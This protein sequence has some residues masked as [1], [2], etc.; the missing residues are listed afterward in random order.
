MAVGFW[1]MSE[2]GQNFHQSLQT[3]KENPLPIYT[4]P[5]KSKIISAYK[6]VHAIYENEYKTKAG[7]LIVAMGTDSDIIEQA[8]IQRQLLLNGIPVIKASFEKLNGN[9]LEINNET[10]ALLIDGL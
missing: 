8:E 7:F 2:A 9:R 1:A 5:C 4:E 6:E 10:G 3:L